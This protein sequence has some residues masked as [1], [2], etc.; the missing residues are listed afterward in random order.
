M[1][2]S[3]EQFYVIALFPTNQL[4]ETNLFNAPNALNP[5]KHIPIFVL[6]DPFI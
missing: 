5:F 6:I 3:L 1:R 2:L 4:N